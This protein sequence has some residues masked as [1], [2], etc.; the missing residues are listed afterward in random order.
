MAFKCCEV[1]LFA[2]NHCVMLY[3]IVLMVL[4]PAVPTV[5]D[6]KDCG[7]QLETGVILLVEMIV[8]GTPYVLSCSLTLAYNVTK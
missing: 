6:N 4:L 5:R 1:I 8:I 3:G 2:L 7:G